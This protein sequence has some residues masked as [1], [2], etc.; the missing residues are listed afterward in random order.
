MKIKKI[1]AFLLAAALIAGGTILLVKRPDI[2]YRAVSA[3][4]D[5]VVQRRNPEK[6][7]IATKRVGID[8]I[9][10]YGAERNDCLMLVNGS[11]LL[12]E[13]YEPELST[14]HD[15]LFET[16]TAEAYPRLANEVEQRFG[17]KLYVSSTYRTAEEQWEI[18]DEQ[19]GDTAQIPGAS[20]HQTG[21]AVDVY[22]PY[23]SG[24]SFIKCRA[25]RWVDDNCQDYGFIVRYPAGASRITGISYEPWHLR[26]V[27]LP[28]SEI[29]AENRLTLEEYA[30]FLGEG[31]V[32]YD[33]YYVSHQPAGDEIDLP[34]SFAECTVSPDGEG[35]WFV[36]AVGNYCSPN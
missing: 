13:H 34:A 4:H 14:Y 29:I 24:D 20:E 30:D 33:G 10:K 17:E 11:H 25:G 31:Y 32:Q 35:G 21:L 5:M 7:E 22:V 12:S 9:E 19:G 28:H 1:I 23:Y 6:A 36:T 8:D 18:Y 27:G 3:V 16:N 2:R 15:V 26:Y